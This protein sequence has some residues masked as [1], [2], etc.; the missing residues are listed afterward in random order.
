MC[1]ITGAE[2]GPIRWRAELLEIFVFWLLAP[3]V[4][5]VSALGVAT[6]CVSDDQEAGTLRAIGC[7]A[8]LLLNYVSIPLCVVL[9]GVWVMRVSMKRRA[10]IRQRLGIDPAWTSVLGDCCLHYWCMWCALAQEMRTVLHAREEGRLPPAGD[11]EAT[12]TCAPEPVDMGARKPLL[13]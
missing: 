10:V 3:I 5:F 13:G 8:C 1:R 2:L 7:L 12:W 9:P 6:A 4:F 11:A